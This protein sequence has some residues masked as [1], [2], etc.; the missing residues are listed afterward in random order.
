MDK[1]GVDPKGRLSAGE[2][3]PVGFIEVHGMYDGVIV[4]IDAF[5]WDVSQKL[6]SRLHPEKRINTDG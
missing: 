5:V 3:D 4:H 6:Q 1:V 2:Y